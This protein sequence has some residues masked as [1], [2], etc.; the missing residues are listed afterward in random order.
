MF[1]FLTR[2]IAWLTSSPFLTWWWWC[3]MWFLRLLTLAGPV[4]GWKVAVAAGVIG[5][6]N[7]SYAQGRADV[8]ELTRWALLVWA[9]LIRVF[10]QWGMW[11]CLAVD[12]ALRIHDDHN[13]VAVAKMLQ[14]MARQLRRATNPLWFPYLFVVHLWAPEH[15]IKN[16]IRRLQTLGD[17][18]AKEAAKK[19]GQPFK[20]FTQFSE[21]KELLQQFEGQFG[22]TLAGRLTVTWNIIW[23]IV[24]A[25]ML[26]GI[27]PTNLWPGL[28]NGLGG[29][30]VKYN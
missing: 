16:K 6:H 24:L 14:R 25:S 27:P 10:A 18:L 5:V 17:D 13:I 11:R 29:V 22:W 19:K 3:Y 28:E 8:M 30:F 9:I 2:P 7:F 15:D 1:R 20:N 4:V 12:P 26:F 21:V 23:L